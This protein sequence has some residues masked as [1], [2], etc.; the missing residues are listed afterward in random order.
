VH[1]LASTC[2]DWNPSSEETGN[3]LYSLERLCRE[4]ELD[5]NDAKK[6][7]SQGTMNPVWPASEITAVYSPALSDDGPVKG[8]RLER[9][10]SRRRAATSSAQQL[11]KG[12]DAEFPG[13]TV[14]E[15]QRA[16][17]RHVDRYWT[18]PELEGV[19]VRSKVGMNT[20]L[21]YMQVNGVGIKSAYEKNRETTKYFSGVKICR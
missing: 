6:A 5:V 2:V 16:N 1:I 11:Y 7:L 20:L 12:S 10:K 15:I 13:W 14:K 17:S 19:M 18:H 8:F 3:Y 9:R 4:I 21:N